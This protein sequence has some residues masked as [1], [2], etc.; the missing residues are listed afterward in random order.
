VLSNNLF[1]PI[2]QA[3]CLLFLLA[4][5]LSHSVAYAQSIENASDTGNKMVSDQP[6]ITRVQAERP[7]EESPSEQLPPDQAVFDATSPM[8][9]LNRLAEQTSLLNF[10]VSFVLSRPDKETL[11]YLWRHAVLDEITNVE[12]LSLLNGP[13]FEQIRYNQVVSIFEPGFPPYSITGES[14]DGPIPLVLL[15]DPQSLK[16]AYEF[17]LIGRNRISG[18]AA[19]QLRIIPRDKTRYGY[20]LW[21]D[22]DTGMLLKLNMYDLK[23]KLLEQIQVTQLNID[24]SV[25]DAFA[26]L[27]LSNLPEVVT[28]K[29]PPQRQ[30][31]WEVSFMPLGM[32]RIKQD[33]HRLAITG[34]IVEYSLLSDGLVDVSV[35]IQQANQLLDEGLDYQLDTTSVL[36]RTNGRIQVTIVGEIPL[37]TAE[38]IEESIV[39]VEEQE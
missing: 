36:S 31:K 32:Q 9:W 15:S 18:R 25:K 7:K 35:Y 1:K 33:T 19:Q 10:E 8:A 17:V 2:Q 3:Y 12:Q 11:P 20:H 34:Q 13:G 27:Q 37:L 14:I 6:Q 16:N 4:A 39:L 5:I 26:S 23:G 22:E 28:M 30:H 29:N 21:L 38:Q 24:D